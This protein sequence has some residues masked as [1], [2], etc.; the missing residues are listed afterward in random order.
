MLP[1]TLPSS[2]LQYTYTEPVR[3]HFSVPGRLI[4]IAGTE[5]VVIT[6]DWSKC[7][8]G[9]QSTGDPPGT[10]Q[11]GPDANKNIV[12]DHK[13]QK[14]SQDVRISASTSTSPRSSAAATGL[15]DKSAHLQTALSS[16]SSAHLPTPRRRGRP[17]KGTEQPPCQCPNCQISPNADRHL[18]HFE[19]CGKTFT[20]RLHL[21]AHI[22]KHVGSRPFACPQLGCDATFIR[23]SELKRHFL[24]HSEEQ[25]SI[26]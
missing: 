14:P 13:Q 11:A 8:T 19:N 5:Y 10:H 17:R 22:R 23:T 18:C 16:S 25:G 6:P 9:V 12:L 3:S 21:E 26:F 2:T 20:K 15:E 1:S 7:G 24:V 4:P